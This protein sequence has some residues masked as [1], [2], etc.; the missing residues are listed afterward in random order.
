MAD[1]VARVRFCCFACKKTPTAEKL[2]AI[3]EKTMAEIFE[4]GFKLVQA[5]AKEMGIDVSDELKAKMFKWGAKNN[6]F[7]PETPEQV[8]ADRAKLD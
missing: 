6:I 4:E 8:A 3:A 7:P 2:D 1:D 5:Q